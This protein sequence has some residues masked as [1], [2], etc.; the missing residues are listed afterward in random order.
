MNT[1]R[2]PLVIPLRRSW[3]SRLAEAWRAWRDEL[4]ARRALREVCELSP[5]MLRDMAVPD[6]WRDAAARCQG[7]RDME[8]S[9]LRSG[10]VTGAPW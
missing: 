5:G 1:H 3:P 4:H 8:R 7:R 9:L 6:D 2:L 10:I